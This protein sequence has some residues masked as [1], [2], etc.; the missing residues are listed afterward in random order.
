MAKKLTR[1]TAKKIIRF[2]LAKKAEEV[3]LLDLRKI[4]PMADFFIICSGVSG[5]QVRAIV[6]SILENCKKSDIDVYHVE[7]YENARWVLIDLVEIVVHVFQPEVR[8]YYQLE[9]LWGDARKDVFADDA[10]GS[11]EVS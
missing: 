10:E 1:A 11:V 5:V 9:R 2:A 8:G 3:I 4:T 7:G 6:D